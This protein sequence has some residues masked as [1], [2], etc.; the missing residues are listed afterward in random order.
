VLGQS[1][2]NYYSWIISEYPR[3]ILERQRRCGVFINLRIYDWLQS[4]QPRSPATPEESTFGGD[5]QLSRERIYLQSRQRESDY[6][7][8]FSL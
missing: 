7:R 6:Y 4:R 2:V 3:D 5:A 1:T 8:I